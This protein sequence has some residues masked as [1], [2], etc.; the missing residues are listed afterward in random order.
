[1]S[2]AALELSESDIERRYKAGRGG[3]ELSKY[4]P[5]IEHHDVSGLGLASR[6]PSAKTGRH[7]HLFSQYTSAAFLELIRMRIV[8]DVREHYP[9][10]R[11]VTREIATEMGV[12]HPIY[13]NGID[14][15]LTTNLLVSVDGPDGAVLFARAGRRADDLD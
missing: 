8:T 4:R 15:V 11:E 13:R 7:H 6:I 9:L 10:D 14:K 5:W 3:G 2:K 1:M 12:P